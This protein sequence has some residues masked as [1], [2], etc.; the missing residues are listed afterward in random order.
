MDNYSG[1]IEKD[2][3]QMTLQE[4]QETIYPVFA[5]YGIGD[6]FAIRKILPLIIAKYSETKK[7]LFLK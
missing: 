5:L 4:L 3:L 7:L 2:I 1:K 6:T